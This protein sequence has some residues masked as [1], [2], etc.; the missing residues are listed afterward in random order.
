M[1]GGATYLGELHLS[2]VALEAGPPPTTNS[3]VGPAGPRSV[4]SGTP[5]YLAMRNSVDTWRETGT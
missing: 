1:A 5:E 4:S 2:K 3:L